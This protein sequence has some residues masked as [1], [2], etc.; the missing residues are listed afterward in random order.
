MLVNNRNTLLVVCH[1][2]FLNDTLFYSCAFTAK[3]RKEK[4]RKGCIVVSHNWSA[5]N[6]GQTNI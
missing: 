4:K 1:F 6:N 5:M 2:T 3:K